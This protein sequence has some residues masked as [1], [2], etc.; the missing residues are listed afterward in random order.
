MQLSES[1]LRGLSLPWSHLHFIKNL[2][3]HYLVAELMQSTELK[4]GAGAIL[5]H[6][7]TIVDTIRNYQADNKELK[8]IAEKAYFR[9]LF[10]CVC[11]EIKQDQTLMDNVMEMVRTKMIDNDNDQF[12]LRIIK[13]VKAELESIFKQ[14]LSSIMGNKK[15][16]LSDYMPSDPETTEES[17]E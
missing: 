8:D 11:D 10:K 9:H 14:D 16:T 5:E 7:D 1:N 2:N 6:K 3:I 13:L 4:Q 15:I 17:D 12:K